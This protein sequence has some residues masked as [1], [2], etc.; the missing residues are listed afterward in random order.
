[1]I[2]SIIRI[3]S[4]IIVLDYFR[5]SIVKHLLIGICKAPKIDSFA[6]SAY[7]ASH[8]TVMIFVTYIVS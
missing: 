5:L 2:L 1:M 6:T 7:S 3:K 4:I 8:Y